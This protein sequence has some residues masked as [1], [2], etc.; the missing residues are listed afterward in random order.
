VDPEL[1][2]AARAYAE[3]VRPRAEAAFVPPRFTQANC[4]AAQFFVACAPAAGR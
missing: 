2:A 1:V 4:H 3:R